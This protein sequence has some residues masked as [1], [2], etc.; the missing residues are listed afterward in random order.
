M[1]DINCV[2][3]FSAA[4]DGHSD[5]FAA[6]VATNLDLNSRG[7][8]VGGGSQW[9]KPQIYG[10][11]LLPSEVSI[12]DF[13]RFRIL[14]GHVRNQVG[15]PPMHAFGCLMSSAESRLEYMGAISALARMSKMDVRV[16]DTWALE[17]EEHR[18]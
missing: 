6:I 7:G 16:R 1:E 18:R 13:N 11:T 14:T 12:L 2:G 10:E 3:R 4:S 5:V 9:K 15:A 17:T 8:V